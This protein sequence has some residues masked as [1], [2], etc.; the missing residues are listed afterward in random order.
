VS[1]AFRSLADLLAQAPPAA[2]E[3]LD[4]VFQ[5]QKDPKKAP[6]RLVISPQL[7]PGQ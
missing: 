3:S 2:E 6:N 5:H 1:R 4:L 7:R